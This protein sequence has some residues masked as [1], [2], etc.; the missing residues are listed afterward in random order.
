MN[1]HKSQLTDK[2]LS[3]LIKYIRFESRINILI[4]H[5]YENNIILRVSRVGAWHHH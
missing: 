5:P 1:Q 2:S 4:V 3:L